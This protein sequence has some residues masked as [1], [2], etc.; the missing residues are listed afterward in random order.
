VRRLISILLAA[1]SVFIILASALAYYVWASFTE[2]GPLAK[3][4]VLVIPK[5]AGV[6]AIAGILAESG[7]IEQP[8]IFRLGARL[9]SRG[10]PLQAGEY[11]FPAG[12]S[13]RAAMRIMIDGKSIQHLVTIAE[14][15]SVAE[16]YAVL[17]VTPLL[18]GAL[19]PPPP[20]GSLLPE[21]YSYLRGENRSTL[22]E[23]MQKG[24][25]RTLDELWPKRSA[26]IGLQSEEEALIL[27]SIVEKETG[28]PSERAHVA[29]VFHNRLRKG[30]KLQSDPTVIYGLTLGQEKLSRPLT[31]D[32]LKMDSPYN[33]YVIEGLPPGPIA[34]PGR[35]SLEAVLRPMASEDLYFVAD[36]SG[37]HAFAKTLEEH[38][39]NVAKWRKVQAQQS[40]N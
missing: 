11:A 3:E 18:E 37:G 28:V 26:A 14:G 32:D 25:R 19:P 30:M 13:P 27:A 40:G 16:I 4:T 24:M 39:K 7:V 38:N 23:R 22:V 9:W 5:G 21:T 17:E 34:N 2:P 20:E 6:A 8:L 12:V 29:S 1:F 35:A 33:T 36:G 31:K 10:R 15:L